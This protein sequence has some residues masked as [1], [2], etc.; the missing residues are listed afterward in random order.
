MDQIKSNLKQ[1][2]RRIENAC[3]EFGRRR[4]ELLLVAVSKTVAIERIIMAY[5]AGITAFG[6]NR[7]QEASA[8]IPK[9]IEQGFQAG[10]HMI[11][12]LQTNKAKPAVRLF[13]IIESIDSLKLAQTVSREAVSENKRVDVLLEVNS[14]GESSKFGFMPGD[15][16]SA[17]RQINKMENLNLR[18]LMT[19]GPF[20]DNKNEIEKAFASAQTLFAQLKSEFGESIDILSM[21][22]SDD[23][24]YA[25][26]YGSTELR[27]GTA[28]FG[29]R[30]YGDGTPEN[31]GGL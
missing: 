2:E 26:K 3:R 31:P 9:F 16:I 23:L 8:K 10:W 13:D 29:V 20:T 18:G 7:V 24:E 14:S 17:A 4:D 6:E 11:G 25:I 30:K 15:V 28:I 21:G 5:Q 12:H 1:L 19:I 22:M 27:I